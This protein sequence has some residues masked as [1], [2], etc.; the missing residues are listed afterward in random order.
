MP[1][2]PIQNYGLIGDM[3]TAALVGD[4]ASIDWFC[5]PRF[6]APSVFAAILD[7][8]KGGRFQLAP[9]CLRAT[10][11]QLYWPDTNVLLTRFLAEEGAAEVRDFMP[12]DTPGR[13]GRPRIM[14]VA[15]SIRGRVPFR[16]ECRPAFAYARE[17]HTLEIDGHQ[18]TFRA[19][20][21]LVLR[22]DSSVPLERD[23]SA[24]V[25]SFE[26]EPDEEARFVLH[27]PDEGGPPC[28]AE[29]VGEAFGAT[30]A[31]WQRW[32]SRCTYRGRWREVVQRS[33]LAL[34][35]LTYEPTGAIVAAPTC[36]LPERIG[37][38]RNWDYRYTWIRD[39]AFTVYGLMRIGFTEEADAFMS[40]L[41]QRCREARPDGAPPLQV[42]YDIDGCADLPEQELSHLD[43]YMGSRPVRIGNAAAAQLQLDIYG[44]LLD[45]AYL[46][47]KY[48]SPTSYDLWVELRR[49]VDWVC[50]NWRRPDAGIWE[51]RGGNRHFVYSK[52]M[53]WVALD[54]GL[55]LAEKRSLP[56]DRTGWYEARDAI[57]RDIMEHGW[58]ES[59]GAFVQAYG[60]E[61]LDASNLIMPLVFF[62]APTD[63]RMIRTLEAIR[64]PLGRGGLRADGLVF[65]YDSERSRDGLEGTEG[66]FNMCSFWLVEAMTRAGRADRGLLR[67]ARLQF[68]H[69]LGYAN[70]LGLYAEETGSRGEALGNFPQAF[71]HLALIS[72]AFNLDRALNQPGGP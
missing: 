55:R 65:R 23:G 7:D 45:A 15:R 3:R 1:Y 17:A 61:T 70:Q 10:R 22:L 29:H 52:L 56:A 14:R 11:K 39:A 28:L 35:L 59:R 68:E 43:G 32:L 24:A 54:R 9:A 46:S 8:A 34:K 67:E 48:A 51:M 30:V 53:S 64:A 62:L 25:A 58:S 66:A 36:G 69:M 13:G 33:A 42:V 37:G 5:Y 12:V 38:E 21:G 19:E 4:D 20:G 16:L 50:E 2:Q 49:L 31:F 63:P 6:D 71:T 44:E 60:E 41:G 47:N 27:E 40:W 26:L 57:Y 18:A 72:A